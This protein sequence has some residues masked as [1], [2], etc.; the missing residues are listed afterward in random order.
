LLVLAI[1]EGYK[2]I[3]LPIAAHDATKIDHTANTMLFTTIPSKKITGPLDPDGHSEWLVHGPTKSK[4]INAPGYPKPVPKPE[5]SCGIQPAY[6]IKPTPGMG[7]GVFATRDIKMDE[8]IF[9]ERPLLV[10]PS[11]NLGV[12]PD[13][14]TKD[15][16][17]KTQIAIV[18][19]EWEKMLEV[20][21]GRMEPENRNAFMELANSHKDDGSGPILG[22]IRTNGF[23]VGSNVFDGP[24]MC[25]DGSNAYSG[26][27]KIGSRINH[28]YVHLAAFFLWFLN[29]I[30]TCI[31]I[32]CMP[33]VKIVFST[34]SF[35]FQCSAIVDIKAGEELFYGYC[36]I[37]QPVARRQVELAPYGIVCS[38]SA[39]THATP[40]TDKLRTEYR[41]IAMD[42]ILNG[43]RVTTPRVAESAIKPVMQ[44]KDALI[45]EGFHYT[46]EYKAMILLIRD[47]YEGIGMKEKAR[48]YKEEYKRYKLPSSS[49]MN[50]D[51]S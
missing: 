49:M 41:K 37:D 18:M 7:L 23:R 43:A 13:P 22:I 15:Y 5:A 2:S 8:L 9:A 11:S 45:R 31:S 40:E 6:V 50:I 35:S 4:V 39:C 3:N 32:S 27:I 38:C 44:F 17:L 28:R 21:V 24:E 33:N 16:D 26:V 46:S 14:K 47:F 10:S 29:N 1:P 48:P 12:R 30:L 36:G 34:P 51:D 19:M 20:A 25:A 42:F